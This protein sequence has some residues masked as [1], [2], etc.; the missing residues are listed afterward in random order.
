MTTTAKRLANH[1]PQSLPYNPPANLQTEIG[2]LR[3]WN[4]FFLVMSGSILV[5][6]VAG[7]TYV[8]NHPGP[9]LTEVANSSP[10]RETVVPAAPA[11]LLPSPTAPKE[12][13]VDKK[14]PAKPS[15]EAKD[16]DKFLEA[17]GSLSAVHLYQTYLNIGLVA[18]A[19]EKETYSKTEAAKILQTVGELIT[20][21]E[22]QLGQLPQ[23]NLDKDD[24]ES[25]DRIRSVT[26]QLRSQASA[27]LS[28]WAAND[29]ENV[30]RYHQAR[31]RSWEDLRELLGIDE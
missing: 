26:S 7:V 20:M 16:R 27:L 10:S 22:K 17:I 21:V 31:E 24:Q 2:R 3:R 25:L 5:A 23:S 4:I 13:I 19:V 29:M 11:K 14:E 15:M 18:D 1:Y 30:A 6:G 9:T 8:Q 12:A 28:F